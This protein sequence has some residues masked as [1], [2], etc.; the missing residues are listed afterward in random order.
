MEK[1]RAEVDRGACG[2]SELCVAS[3]LTLRQIEYA[4]SRIVLTLDNSRD[5]RCG[6]VHFPDRTS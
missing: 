2:V 1:G 5:L 6:T 4:A 3:S